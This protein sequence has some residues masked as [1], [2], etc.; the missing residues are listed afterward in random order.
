MMARFGFRLKHTVLIIVMLLCPVLTLAQNYDDV[1]PNGAEKFQTCLRQFGSTVQAYDAQDDFGGLG[2]YRLSVNN[3]FAANV[4]RGAAPK[5]V[6]YNWNYCDFKG[7]PAVYNRLFSVGNLLAR[8][9]MQDKLVQQLIIAKSVNQKDLLLQDAMQPLQRFQNSADLLGGLLYR[10]GV[11]A[12]K[13]LAIADIN[14]FD[15]L[16]YSTRD[17]VN[18]YAQCAGD[19][20]AGQRRALFDAETLPKTQTNVPT[21]ALNWLKLSDMPASLKEKLLA[22]VPEL[23]LV[24]NPRE[25]HRYATFTFGAET[26]QSI[27]VGLTGVD[28]CND[29]R[30]TYYLF[31]NNFADALT[32]YAGA[33]Q[34]AGNQKGFYIDGFYKPVEELNK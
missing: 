17:Y 18:F 14:S 8:P 32:F 22:K 1:Q 24:F 2:S 31:R 34:G 10:K 15:G 7:P 6:S 26:T 9:A 4:C 33:V 20:T 27:L 13:L 30:C 16:G 3:L 19:N 21:I 11:T 29:T 28:F 5:Y 12:V 23:R 25:E